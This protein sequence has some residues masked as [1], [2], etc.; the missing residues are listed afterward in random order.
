MQYSTHGSSDT[1]DCILRRDYTPIFGGSGPLDGWINGSQVGLLPDPPTFARGNCPGVLGAGWGCSHKLRA[2]VYFHELRAWGF[3]NELQLLFVS[4]AMSS[5]YSYSDHAHISYELWPTCLIFWASSSLILLLSW[6]STTYCSHAV[7]ISL[8]P[9][10]FSVM[11]RACGYGHELNMIAVMSS[12][13]SNYLTVMSSEQ[14]AAIVSSIACLYYLVPTIFLFW[15]IPLC[16]CHELR[17]HGCHELR[18][19]TVF[20]VRI[21][22]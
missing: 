2:R 10:H 16:C 6:V 4:A 22:D 21:S 11:L 3:C 13:S 19:C 8:S 1:R 14:A 17:P 7:D 20:T 9:I 15:E 12:L 18:P 5:D